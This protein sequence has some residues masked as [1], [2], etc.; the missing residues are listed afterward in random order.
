[1][2]HLYAYFMP[3]GTNAYIFLQATYFVIKNSECIDVV[4][5]HSGNDMKEKL[6][7]HNDV[8]RNMALHGHAE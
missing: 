6:V 3:Q 1:M 2:R 5:Q 8:K 4:M 7:L